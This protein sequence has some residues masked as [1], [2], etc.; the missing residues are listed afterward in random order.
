MEGLPRILDL[1]RMHVMLDSRQHL[2]RQDPP[3]SESF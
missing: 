2:R 1:P 3:L